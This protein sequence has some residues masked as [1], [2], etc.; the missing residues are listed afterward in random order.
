MCKANSPVRASAAGVSCPRQTSPAPQPSISCTPPQRLC[1]KCFQ[2]EAILAFMQ[3]AKPESLI[4]LAANLTFINEQS[5][6]LIHG[7][8]PK[9]KTFDTT[10]ISMCKF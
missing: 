10:I 6:I 1:N 5:A 4:S 3:T 7:I 2:T 8:I 9:L